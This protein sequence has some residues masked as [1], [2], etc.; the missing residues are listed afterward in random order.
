MPQ[1]HIK[2]DFAQIHFTETEPALFRVGL[3]QNSKNRCKDARMSYDPK[4]PR[5]GKK[6]PY[7]CFVIRFL[8]VTYAFL[9]P[10]DS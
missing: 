8:L 1:S 10:I 6:G 4:D 5:L 2:C 7:F 3:D 9:R